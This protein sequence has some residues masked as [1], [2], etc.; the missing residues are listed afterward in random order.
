MTDRIPCCVEGCKR[1]ADP[2]KYD[3]S[4]EIICAKHWAKVPQVMKARYRQMRARWRK[5]YRRWEK[6]PE[7]QQLK[8][9]Y[10][11][12]VRLESRN[13]QA[14]KA[15]MNKPDEPFDD[16]PGFLREMGLD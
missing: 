2:A 11:R 15:H 8:R 14:I 7:N 12:V 13:W 16:L 5:A 3:G 4:T 9:I 1:T 10:W 6:D